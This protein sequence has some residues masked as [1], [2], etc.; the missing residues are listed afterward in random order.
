M[1]VGCG[2]RGCWCRAV[3]GLA[4]GGAGR[5]V[6]E[7]VR[8]HRISEGSNGARDTVLTVRGS[9]WTLTDEIDQIT[10]SASPGIGVPGL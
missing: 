10:A 4:A 2:R 5:V 9:R 3:G 8:I 7:V 1:T 6:V